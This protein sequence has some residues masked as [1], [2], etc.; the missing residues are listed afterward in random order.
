MA[1]GASQLPPC[2]VSQVLLSLSDGLHV[3]SE[4]SVGY[5]C[6]PSTPDPHCGKLAPHTAPTLSSCRSLVTLTSIPFAA[7]LLS[8]SKFFSAE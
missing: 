7:L 2:W 5:E 8:L 1:D 3:N 4:L 6:L